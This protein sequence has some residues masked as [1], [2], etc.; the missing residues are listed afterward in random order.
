MSVEQR[1][2]T[3]KLLPIYENQS[4]I[5]PDKKRHALLRLDY[6]TEGTRLEL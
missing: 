4:K 2:N 6:E 5:F 3:V 1:E